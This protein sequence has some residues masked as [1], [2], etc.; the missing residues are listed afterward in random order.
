MNSY[1]RPETRNAD[2]RFQRI[3]DEGKCIGCGLCAS[4][5]PSTIRMKLADSGYLRPSTTTPVSEEEADAIYEFCPGVVQSGLPDDLLSES[6]NLDAVWGPWHRIEKVYAVDSETRHKGATSGSLTALAQFLVDSGTVASVLHIRQGGLQPSLGKPQ[7]STNKSDVLKGAGSCYAPA[8]PL[9]E[10]CALLDRGE[11][12]AVVAKPCDISAV[13]LLGR[14][15]ERVGEL[16]T[17]CLAMV[18][19]GIMPPFGMNEFLKRSGVSPINVA[20]VSYRG[21]GCPG[22]IRVELQNGEV[23][24]KTYLEFWGTD[25]TMWHLPWR[26]KVCPDGNG[27]AADIAA[28]DTWPGGSPSEESMKADPG[29]NV[30]IARTKAGAQLLRDAIDAGFLASDGLA[31]TADLDNWQPHQ[32]RKKL[33][34]E[35]RYDGM[36]A[37]GQLRIRTVNL[38]TDTLRGKMDAATDSAQIEGTRQRIAIGKHRDDFGLE[39]E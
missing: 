19:G 20:T 9:E 21:N 15:D 32:V 3:L 30:V 11:K 1:D 37:E 16:V 14:N 6:Q 24:E 22:P 36:Q 10:L 38:R 13:R 35:A 34:S 17:H 23:I 12:F 26:C 8:A 29:T 18:C 33:A 4:M 5:Y 31:T 28:A 2:Q 25:A 7:I 27:E 39:D